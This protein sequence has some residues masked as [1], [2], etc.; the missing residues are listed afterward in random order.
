MHILV[1]TALPSS[2][3]DIQNEMKCEE[4]MLK[5]DISGWKFLYIYNSMKH[6]PIIWIEFELNTSCKNLF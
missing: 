4:W 6:Q 1:V 3:C 5:S 2:N